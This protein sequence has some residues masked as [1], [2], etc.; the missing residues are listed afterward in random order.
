MHRAGWGYAVLRSAALLMAP[1][2][3]KVLLM[4]GRAQ[5]LPGLSMW[6]QGPCLLVKTDLLLVALGR[7]R[8]WSETPRAPVA[9]SQLVQCSLSPKSPTQHAQSPALMVMRVC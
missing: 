4:A 2:A 3:D 5:I 6:P 7:S 1:D 9:E 8:L